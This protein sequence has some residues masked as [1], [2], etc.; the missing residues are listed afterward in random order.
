VSARANNQAVGAHTRVSHV[1]I[2]GRI[3]NNIAIREA[4][5][6]NPQTNA[7]AM[8]RITQQVSSQLEQEAAS[9]FANASKELQTKTYGPLR[10][11]NLYPD[12]MQLSTTAS[13][14]NLSSRLMDADEIGGS[15]S[16]PIAAVPSTGL[17]AQIHES[18]LTHAFDRLGLNGQEMTEDQVRE[19]L[20][21]RLSEIL[22]RPVS[23]PKPQNAAPEEEQAANT[24]VFDQNDPVRFTITDGVVTLIIRAGLKRNNGEDIPTQIISVPFTPTLQGDKIVLTRGNVGVKPVTRPPNVSAQVARAQIMRQKI[25]SALPEQ[26]V[27]ATF[28]IEQ[29]NKTVKLTLIELIAQGGWLTLSFQ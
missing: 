2:L 24:L 26:T 5:A 12:V 10:K 14:L 29:Q 20:E 3:A 6:R 25:Q 8:Q 1:P 11:Y 7:M 13:E 21:S 28:E 27:D 16:A 15:Q 23:I 17:V 4:N 22:G 19:L 9:Q 18:L